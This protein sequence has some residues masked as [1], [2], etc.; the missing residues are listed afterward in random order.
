MRELYNLLLPNAVGLNLWQW[1]SIFESTHRLNL[2]TP[3][4]EKVER[5]VL[6]LK[7]FQAIDSNNDGFI[8]PQSVDS[9]CSK[10][11][12]DFAES[13]LLLPGVFLQ[14]LQHRTLKWK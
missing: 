6:L 4:A 13:L 9:F 12:D 2:V 7:C 10:A 11:S 1:N 8:D 3:M 5:D 14:V